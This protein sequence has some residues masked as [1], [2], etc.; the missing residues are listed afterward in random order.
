MLSA[1]EFD[2]QLQ[3]LAIMA[4]GG[5]SLEPFLR[6][7]QES[8]F[9]AEW[10]AFVAGHA[11]HFTA[12][13]ADGSHKLEWT[14]L[15]KEYQN[16][17]DRQ[18]D[19]VLASLNMPKE[20]FM[21]FCGWLEECQ[22][23]LEDDYVLPGSGGLRAGDFQGFISAL[24]A[25]HSYDN[26]LRVMCEEVARQQQNQISPPQPAAA[27]QLQ[28]I[29]V[30]V[31]AGIEAGQAMNVEYNGTTYAIAVPDGC[32]PGTSFRVQIPA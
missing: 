2:R 17:F 13:N 6:G 5:T 28:E 10:Q 11:G 24:T 9:Q 8:S 22:E 30:T 1:D 14:P 18:M 7:F 29:E 3:Q 23:N 21:E 16:M 20:T 4:N 15:H 26:F 27:A 12:T 32:G 25:S 19:A 31:P